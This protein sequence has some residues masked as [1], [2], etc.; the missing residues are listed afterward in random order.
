VILPT[1]DNLFVADR[2]LG[3]LARYMRLMGYDVKYPPPCSDAKLLVDTQKER[4][5]LL[6]RDTGFA[7]CKATLHANPKVLELASPM[8]LT[9]VRQ[10]L[11]EGFI[12]HIRAARCPACNAS[13]EIININEGR[14][15]LPCFIITTQTSL[16]YCPC[17]NIILWEGT[18]WEHFITEISHILQ[19][20]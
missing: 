14:H 9:Q 18:H 2:M 12:T 4:R 6:T 19:I 8:V 16:R 1:S 13:L 5:V 10:L 11:E 7:K 17:C 20:Y 15:L 3:K